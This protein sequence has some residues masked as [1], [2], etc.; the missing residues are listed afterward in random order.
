MTDRKK[1][2]CLLMKVCPLPFRTIGAIADYLIE[3]GVTFGKS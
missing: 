1:L 2:I 3:R